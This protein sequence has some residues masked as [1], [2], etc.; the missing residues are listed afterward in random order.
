MKRKKLVQT[1]TEIAM[2]HNI[3]QKLETLTLD[4]LDQLYNAIAAQITG[5]N[6]WVLVTTK[7]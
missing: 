6:G 4:S 5:R 3:M 2:L 1:N 7:D